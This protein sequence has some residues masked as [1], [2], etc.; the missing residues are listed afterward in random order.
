[1]DPNSIIAPP[2][3]TWIWLAPDWSNESATQKPGYTH[4]KV[5][6]TRYADG[7]I[8]RHVLDEN[9]NPV[10]AAGTPARTPEEA[11][12]LDPAPVYDKDQEQRF[13]EQQ[14]Q[15]QRQQ[16][17]SGPP[18]G[19]PT[20]TVNGQVFAWNPE[21]RAY[22]IPTGEQ[23]A[24]SQSQAAAPGGKPFVDDGPE[25]GEHGRRWGWNPETRLYDRDLG[26]SPAAQKPKEEA[27]TAVATKPLE[28][29][30][31]WQVGTRAKKDA[32]GNSVTE[33]YY[34]NPQGQETMT[35]PKAS[36]AVQP[37]LAAD[38]KSWGYFDTTDPQN[39]RWVTI[40]PDKAPPLPGEPDKPP[41]NV[42]GVYGTWKQQD[43][44][45]TFVP[46]AEQP[47]GIKLPSG[48]PP[49]DT[50]SP[51]AAF[52]SFQRLTAW[53]HQQVA[54]GK[55]KPGDVR[56]V[57]E[58]PHAQVS[59]ILDREKSQRADA[60]SQRGQD[61]SIQTNALSNATSG[62]TSTLGQAM[63]L[64]KGVDP[65]HN[66]TMNFL[67]GGLAL[68]QA[69]AANLG[70]N[71]QG[72]APVMANPL[73]PGGGVVPGPVA[74]GVRPYAPGV[75]PVPQNTGAGEPVSTPAI[76]QGSGLDPNGAAVPAPTGVGLPPPLLPPRP[77]VEPVQPAPEAAPAADQQAQMQMDNLPIM[78]LNRSMGI[79]QGYD[80]AI[81][82]LK[83]RGFDDATIQLAMQ[84]HLMGA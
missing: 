1:M 48:A 52:D 18:G 58:A 7:R 21:T 80:P 71:P 70:W 6:E 53:V 68:Q 43:G 81:A 11:R 4:V 13:K 17:T 32:N 35:P 12:P 64:A 59:M 33:T 65:G 74:S 10:T 83:A 55:L 40:P 84:Q 16:A 37:V 8:V 49:M 5:R 61:V 25:A 60:L 57:L 75:T 82:A 46:V 51:Q 77:P 56:S 62:Y 20:R 27:T 72:I 66:H 73:A 44:A 76:L 42:E 28:G 78:A 63:N 36:S 50:S 79:G 19:L 23:P 39:P 22:D 2:I 15:A 30:P 3:D 45:W 47:G 67:L 26:P 14:A 69:Q 24:T 41:T 29:Q 54:E 38:K 31:G 34:V 9:G